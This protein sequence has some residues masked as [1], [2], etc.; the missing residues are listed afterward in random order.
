MSDLI[1]I[2][3]IEHAF[4]RGWVRSLLIPWKSRMGLY[5]W[6]IDISFSWDGEDMEVGEHDAIMANVTPDWTRKYSRMRL[7]MF[8][9]LQRDQEAIER[10]LVHELAH[11]LVSEMCIPEWLDSGGFVLAMMKERTERVVTELGAAFWWVYHD[12]LEDGELNA[13]RNRRP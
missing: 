5:Q 8:E 2:K 1:P 11:I 12:G 9:L 10:I 6:Q 13:D 4:E 3:S 7:N